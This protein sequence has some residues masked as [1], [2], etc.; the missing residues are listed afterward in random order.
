MTKPVQPCAPAASPSRLPA[1]LLPTPNP[2]AKPTVGIQHGSLPEPVKTNG[3]RQ[4]RQDQPRPS[5]G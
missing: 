4:Y 3:F 5:Q 2:K 1:R